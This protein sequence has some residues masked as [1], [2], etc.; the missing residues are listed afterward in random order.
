MENQRTTIFLSMKTQINTRFCQYSFKVSFWF[1]TFVNQR[2]KRFIHRKKKNRVR[3]SFTF[4]L[5]PIL[6]NNNSQ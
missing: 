2:I 3:M 6:E 1:L 4:G 5:S